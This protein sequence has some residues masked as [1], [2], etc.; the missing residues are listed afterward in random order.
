MDI[1]YYYENTSL[2]LQEISNKLTLSYKIVW[3]YVA[4][5][6]SAEYRKTRKVANYRKSK[7]G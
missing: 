2:T 1:K 7:L 6:Y 3:Q 5:H 4:R